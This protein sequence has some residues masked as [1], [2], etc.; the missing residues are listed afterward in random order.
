MDGQ[1]HA[2]SNH[3]SG[4]PAH[5]HKSWMS[6]HCAFA[7]TAAGAP[8][9]CTSIIAAVMQPRGSKPHITTVPVPL[10]FRFRI[11]QPR[12]PPSLS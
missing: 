9:P 2:V 10:D 5:D 4:S 3:S 11:A 1:T 7:A 8:P 6:G 12:G